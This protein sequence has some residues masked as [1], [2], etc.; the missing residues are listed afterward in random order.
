[1]TAQRRAGALVRVHQRRYSA[2]FISGSRGQAWAIKRELDRLGVRYHR[3]LAPHSWSV[4][5]SGAEDAMAAL[6][7]AGYR[8]EMVLL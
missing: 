7:V 4:L 1:M 5:G 2:D 8:V 3:A 6:E